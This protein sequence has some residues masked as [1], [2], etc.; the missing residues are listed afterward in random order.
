MGYWLPHAGLTTSLYIS[1]LIGLFISQSF[2]VPQIHHWSPIL[3]IGSLSNLGCQILDLRLFSTWQNIYNFRE[4]PERRFR[5]FDGG[6]ERLFGVRDLCMGHSTLSPN[7]G[8]WELNT[9]VGFIQMKE[10]EFREY[11][12]G[13]KIRGRLLVAKMLILLSYLFVF[14]FDKSEA[15]IFLFILQEENLVKRQNYVTS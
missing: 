1:P 8:R 3:Y 11:T 13:H 4:T 7:T 2:L 6:V 15:K 14:F 5:I 9:R 12:C 10:G